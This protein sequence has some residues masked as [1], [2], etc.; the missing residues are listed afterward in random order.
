MTREEVGDRGV[1][2]GENR[3][4]GGGGHLRVLVESFGGPGFLGRRSRGWA[5]SGGGR[6]DERNSGR[7]GGR[8]RQGEDGRLE[9][10]NGN[11]IST[12]E[13]NGMSEEGQ[14]LG[15][16]GGAELLKWGTGDR[17]G[18]GGVGRGEE[19]GSGRNGARVCG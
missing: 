7:G 14:N 11:G 16:A 15:P 10:L 19:G 17:G 9:M 3:M 5:I 6:Q 12:R 8:G 4:G 1:G 13:S 2:G 18:C